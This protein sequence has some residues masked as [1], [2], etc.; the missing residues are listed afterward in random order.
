MYFDFAFFFAFFLSL[1]RL[2]SLSPS[3][4][5][6]R[7]NYSSGRERLRAYQSSPSYLLRMVI[8]RLTRNFFRVVLVEC[9]ALMCFVF[10]GIRPLALIPS[11]AQA[12]VII[13]SHQSSLSQQAQDLPVLYRNEDFD[14]TGFAHYNVGVLLVSGTGYG[15]D[16]EKCSPAIDMALDYVNQVFLRPHR[17][18]LDKVQRRYINLHYVKPSCLLFPRESSPTL[19]D[20]GSQGI[21]IVGS[22]LLFRSSE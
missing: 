22:N 9:I 19:T 17:I 10:V 11:V 4:S 2:C 16:L 15:F 20:L 21:Q 1:L 18:H 14:N 8:V 12:G 6:E 7:R 3:P 5:L 13:Q